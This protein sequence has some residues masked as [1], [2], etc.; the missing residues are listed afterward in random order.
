MHPRALQR[1]AATVSDFEICYSVERISIVFG[2]TG[3]SAWDF[4]ASIASAVVM[5]A[6]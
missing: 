3:S 5:I 1:S 6:A 4:S 2:T